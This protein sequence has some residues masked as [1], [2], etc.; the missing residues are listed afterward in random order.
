VLLFKEIFLNFWATTH[1]RLL[2][3]RRLID[4][5]CDPLV[6]LREA[7]EMKSKNEVDVFFAA[8]CSEG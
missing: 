3:S 1:I 5:K 7:T 2:C 4:D 8:P 6:G